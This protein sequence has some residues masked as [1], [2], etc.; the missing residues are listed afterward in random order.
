MRGA[1]RHFF[2]AV[3]EQAFN[4]LT[5]ATAGPA[6]IYQLKLKFMYGHYVRANVK[7][8]QPTRITP[9]ASFYSN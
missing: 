9:A 5:S 1:A 6:Q 2:L 8:S 3:F 7:R 4:I